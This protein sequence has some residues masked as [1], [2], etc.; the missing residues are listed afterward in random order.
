MQYLRL[1]SS[2][3][4]VNKCMTL[5]PSHLFHRRDIPAWKFAD[6]PTRT[7]TQGKRILIAFDSFPLDFPPRAIPPGRSPPPWRFFSENNELPYSINTKPITCIWNVSYS[8]HSHRPN[9]KLLNYT[10]IKTLQNTLN[11]S[12]TMIC[13]GVSSFICVY[14]MCFSLV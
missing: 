4:S 3:N 5:T 14:L 1:L 11:V 7:A 6:Y 8:V 2:P 12:R 13:Y 10:Y 9:Y